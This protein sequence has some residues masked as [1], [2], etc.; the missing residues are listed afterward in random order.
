VLDHFG[1]TGC[2]RGEVDESCFGDGWAGASV[3]CVLADGAEGCGEVDDFLGRASADLDDMFEGRAVLADA[4]DFLH[5]Y[6]V[7]DED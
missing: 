1:V 5:A 4:E 2:A 7:A 6:G 3:G